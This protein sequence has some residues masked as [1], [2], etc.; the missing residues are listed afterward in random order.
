MLLYAF[1]G[2]PQ[3]YK[4]IENQKTHDIWLKSQV[5]KKSTALI[6]LKSV[7]SEIPPPPSVVPIIS[8][9]YWISYKF[10]TFLAQKTVYILQF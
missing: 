8:N 10:C 2:A 6:S 3:Y 5:I 9:Y 7:E 4:L 1:D